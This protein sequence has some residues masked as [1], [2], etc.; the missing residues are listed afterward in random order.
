MS[1]KLYF[2]FAEPR[3]N[4]ALEFQLIVEVSVK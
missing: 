1:L 3:P 2:E 4:V